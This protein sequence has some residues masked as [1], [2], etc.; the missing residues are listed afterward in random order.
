VLRDYVG[1]EKLSLAT[2]YDDVPQF[3]VCSTIFRIGVSLC[4]VSSI[5]QYKGIVVDGV[6]TSRQEI[7]T[8]PFQL[9]TGSVWKAIGDVDLG[10]YQIQSCCC[11]GSK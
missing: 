8:R 2:I 11:M 4:Q 9:V 3:L 10:T 6:A 7:S 1:V 5:L